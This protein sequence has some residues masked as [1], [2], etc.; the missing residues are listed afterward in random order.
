MSGQPPPVSRPQPVVAPAPHVNPAFFPAA[1]T[2]VL[3][4]PVRHTQVVTHLISP[5]S[6]DQCEMSDYVQ[7]VCKQNMS[8]FKCIH[9]VSV[10][11]S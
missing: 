1:H 11:T 3:P 6:D 10:L 4:P 2:A 8:K 7:V 5:R 9:F